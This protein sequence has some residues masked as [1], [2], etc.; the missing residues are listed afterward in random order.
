MKI[1][2]RKLSAALTVV[3]LL[4]GLTNHGHAQ[5]GKATTPEEA[6]KAYKTAIEAGD[7]K[8]VAELTAGE[9]GAIL[10]KMA[11]KLAQAKANSDRLDKALKEK[12]IKF[13]N[14]FAAG[15]APFADLEFGVVEVG[16]EGAKA[17]ARIKVG[18]RGKGQEE[19][20]YVQSEGGAWRV[21]LPA[22]LAR[23]LRPLASA[24]RLNRHLEGLTKLTD[25]LNTVTGEVLNGTLKTKDEVLLRVVK[26]CDQYQLGKLL[27]A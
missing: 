26:L 2:S 18:P 7:I 6:L 9:Y 21:D 27:G 25:L 8:A 4:S 10:R 1:H 13:D 5:G 19:T 17:V 22:D 16:K 3:A 20:V 11:E 23:H 24:E 14:P 15:L 12:D